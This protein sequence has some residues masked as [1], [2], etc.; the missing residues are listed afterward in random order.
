MKTS[1]QVERRYIINREQKR[2]RKKRDRIE[3]QNSLSLFVCV[4][5]NLGKKSSD[6]VG[7][8]KTISQ[9]KVASNKRPLHM[10]LF[11]LPIMMRMGYSG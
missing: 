1:W 7:G 5:G 2:K 11:L 3:I 9:T 10:L 6:S 8:N 4:P